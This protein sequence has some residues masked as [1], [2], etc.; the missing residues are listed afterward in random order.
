M[1]R[2]RPQ[3]SPVEL[4]NKPVR[5]R[6]LSAQAGVSLLEL[7][8]SLIIFGIIV[9]PLMVVPLR[10]SEASNANSAR[11]IL[12][13]EIQRTYTRFQEE[14]NR[15][16]HFLPI[17]AAANPTA[18]NAM[19]FNR[20]RQIF[21]AYFNPV[22][23]EE[24][25]VGYMWDEI[26]NGGAPYSPR[27]WRL[28]RVQIPI[29][30]DLQCFQAVSDTAAAPHNATPCD[31]DT[32][33]PNWSSANSVTSG[34]QVYI[35]TVSNRVPIFAYCRD[36][37]CGSGSGDLNIDPFDADSVRIQGFDGV[38]TSTPFVLHY[39]YQ[40][41]ERDMQPIYA[42]LASQQV[43]ADVATADQEILPFT[44]VINEWNHPFRER[45]VTMRRGSVSTAYRVPC[46]NIGTDI[47]GCT[48]TTA[49]VA[50]VFDLSPDAMHFDV[51]TG[52]LYVATNTS[53]IAVT[54]PEYAQYVFR[55]KPGM[56]DYES[57]NEVFGTFDANDFLSSTSDPY[58]I[59]SHSVDRNFIPRNTVWGGRAFGMT[60]DNEGNVYVLW[61]G[62]GDATTG[63]DG[64]LFSHTPPARFEQLAQ[65][66]PWVDRWLFPAAEAAAKLG[67]FAGPPCL[68]GVCDY[69]IVGKY[70][71]Q[72]SLI[73]R[74]N[75]GAAQQCTNTLPGMVLNP[76]APA[77]L[78]VV[79]EGALTGTNGTF[80]FT[81]PKDQAQ[82][83]SNY[84]T[85]SAVTG[86]LPSADIFGDYQALTQSGM[87]FDS[88]HQ[89]YIFLFRNTADSNRTV[90]YSLPADLTNTDGTP[91]SRARVTTKVFFRNES[92]W[93]INN[94]A[95]DDGGFL[96]SIA[97]D[98][99]TNTVYI[100]AN[101][102]REPSVGYHPPSIMQIIPN[103]R[104]GIVHNNTLN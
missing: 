36:G 71:Q 7:L 72:G 47:A 89:R 37:R 70:S 42:R 104:L 69:S 55:L 91:A 61:R 9:L 99:L 52:L 102:A 94:G 18:N 86:S 92:N 24:V 85:Y 16:Y 51:K 59:V 38:T 40:A 57:F 64:T 74:L 100:G 56:R 82:A 2:E 27:R 29:N 8:I 96:R 73:H 45:A 53:S 78:Q 95:I 58:P 10:A 87:T 60:M 13:V 20:N 32:V 44:T 62:V 88:L 79:V 15:A 48:V 67:C 98:P 19:G 80:M 103:T 30:A 6:V 3:E 26:L 46:E 34:D 50:P 65:Q 75:L 68:G 5:D 97:Y 11:T 81:Y 31:D 39:R 12:D 93:A 21:F 4:M 63:G 54:D 77:E 22:T 35:E 49:P 23:N 41:A 14:V 28:L 76:A 33:N 17:Q 84:V 83:I 25:R 90:I 66:R 101:T 1:L 43:Q